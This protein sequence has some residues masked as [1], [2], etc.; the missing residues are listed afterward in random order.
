[1]WAEEGSSDDDRPSF[2]KKKGKNSYATPVDFVSGGIKQ[3]DG[4]IKKEAEEDEG[5]HQH[6][7]SF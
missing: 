7:D 5:E 3:S 6:E 4:K 1:M 2:G